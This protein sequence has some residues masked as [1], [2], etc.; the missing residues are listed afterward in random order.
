MRRRAESTFHCG[1]KTLNLLPSCLFPPDIAKT[2]ENMLAVISI[3][4][5]SARLPA[6][7]P[8]PA[9]QKPPEWLRA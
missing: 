5:E 4:L 9:L 6:Q 7:L 8:N 2:Q 3:S 1:G